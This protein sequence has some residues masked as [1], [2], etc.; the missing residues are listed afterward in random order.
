MESLKSLQHKEYLSEVATIVKLTLAIPATNASSERTLSSLRG[1]KT[2][3]SSTIMQPCVNHLLILLDHS[4]K[5]DMLSL[6]D[7]A[8]DF[9]AMHETHSSLFGKF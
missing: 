5:T 7:V 4:N 8:N 2:Y 6:K 1:V 9:V 3:L